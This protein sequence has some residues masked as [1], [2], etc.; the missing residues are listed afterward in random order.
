MHDQQASIRVHPTN[1][2]GCSPAASEF[3]TRLSWT[4]TRTVPAATIWPQLGI[5]ISIDHKSICRHWR[6]HGASR[7]NPC[8]GKEA[9]GQRWRLQNKAQRAGVMRV[10]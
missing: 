1:S 7:R 3:R 4:A 6:P 10:G 5:S 2:S 9:L 8:A